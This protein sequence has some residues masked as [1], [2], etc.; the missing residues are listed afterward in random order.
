MSELRCAEGMIRDPADAP[1][2]AGRMV[3]GKVGNR[4]G[5]PGLTSGIPS[6]LSAA[7]TVGEQGVMVAL[8]PLIWGVMVAGMSS[9][10]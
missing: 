10:T 7:G 2:K 8:N 1:R 9:S 5:N 4:L 6:N 3:S